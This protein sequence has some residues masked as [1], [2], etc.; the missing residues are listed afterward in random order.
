MTVL[1]DFTSALN[2]MYMLAH[3]LLSINNVDL[4]LACWL[5]DF[6]TKKEQK[7]SEMHVL[8]LSTWQAQK[9]HAY[10]TSLLLHILKNVFCCTTKNHFLLILSIVENEL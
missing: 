4:D 2:C 8:V 6:L 7:L 5:V 10:S 1:I 9:V 3:Q